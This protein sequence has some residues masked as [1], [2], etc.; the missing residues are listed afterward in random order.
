MFPPGLEAPGGLNI[1]HINDALTRPRVSQV[2]FADPIKQPRWSEE[3]IP[4]IDDEPVRLIL[5]PKK[6]QKRMEFVDMN[7]QG[8]SRWGG[9]DD[10]GD[11]AM[12]EIMG[13]EDPKIA[14]QLAYER[15]EAVLRGKELTGKG[16]ADKAGGVDMGRQK[17]RDV[18]VGPPKGYVQLD[19]DGE[20]VDTH[21]VLDLTP[22]LKKNDPAYA[23]GK[24]KA[25]GVGNWAKEP[26]KHDLQVEHDLDN[27]HL[28]RQEKIIH[29]L[30]IDINTP[31]LPQHPLNYLFTS[32]STLNRP[33][34]RSSRHQP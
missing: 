24:A 23:W 14:R 31:T 3:P 32:T 7:K 29:A 18:A 21:H 4:G 2:V 33:C 10:V 13:V 19:V 9:N 25:G 11:E 27:E 34:A 20:V 6:T 5:S 12:Q 15:E 22:G 16:K 30:S 17:G 28:G 8:G 26:T 1:Q